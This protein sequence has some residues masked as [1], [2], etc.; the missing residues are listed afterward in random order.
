MKYQGIRPAPGYPSQPDHTEKRA[1][2]NL[3]QAD[4]EI[5]LELSE[6]LA[7][8]PASAVSALVFGHSEAKYFAV[9]AVNKDQI[10]SYAVRKGDDLETVERWL[11]PILNYDDTK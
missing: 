2:W 6:S 11:A 3:L 7:M 1:M 5:G 10:E 9:G 4:K 8:M